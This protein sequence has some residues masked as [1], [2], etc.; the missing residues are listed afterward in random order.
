MLYWSI[1]TLDGIESCFP[2]CGLNQNQGFSFIH[3]HASVG[4]KEPH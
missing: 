4:I 1:E 3:I 2:V